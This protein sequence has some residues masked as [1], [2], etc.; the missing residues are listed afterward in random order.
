MKYLI[1]AL[2]FVIDDRYRE[3]KEYPDPEGEDPQ[4]ADRVEEPHPRPEKGTED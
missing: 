1:T 4:D 3:G 2:A